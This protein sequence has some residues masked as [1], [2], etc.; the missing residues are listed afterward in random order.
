MTTSAVISGARVLLPD[1]DPHQPPLRD[2]HI[3]HGRIAR[4]VAPGVSHSDGAE[5]IDGSGKLVVPGFVNAHYHSYDVLAKGLMEDMP[6]DLWALLSQPGYWGQ[7]SA[8]ELRL[9][10]LVG[11]LE[12]LRNGVTCVQDMNTIVPHDEAALD[13]ILSAYEE[14][15]LRVVLSLAVRDVAELDIAPFLASDL[16][17]AVRQIVDGVPGDAEAELAFVAAQIDRIGTERPCLHWA[18]SPSG[19]QRCSTRLLEGLGEI[20]KAHRLP[21]LTHVYETRA[22]LAKA[23]SAYPEHGGSLIRRL[24]DTGLLGPRTTIAHSVWI[25][26]GEIRALAE[27]GAGIAHNPMAN[28]KLKSGI[29]P[30]VDLEAAGVN[31]ALGCDNCS[32]GDT[33]NMFQAMKLFTLLAGAMDGLPTGMG[34]ASALRAATTGGARA[35]GLQD[36][37]GAIAEG[38]RADLSL[39]DLSDIA[40]QPFNSALRQLVYSECGRGVTTVMVE[41]RVVMRD[42]RAT[43]LDEHALRAELS[44]LMVQYRAEFSALEHRHAPAFPHLLEAN[45]HLAATD[46]GMDRFITRA[47]PGAY[48]SKRETQL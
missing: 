36:E 1:A 40:Y 32:C 15:G 18:I 46:L 29:A 2:L 24:A 8:A 27:A 39:I 37:I 7:R 43:G 34:A 33:Q 25:T 23:R 48:P 30:L 14:L 12:C 10:T 45:R 19:P 3:A 22:Q 13:T 17:P 9:R 47:T 5:V 4:I 28:L 38:M 41:G 31:I 21:V 42:G 11:G 35:V 16:P 26:K 20:A 44:E 6:F